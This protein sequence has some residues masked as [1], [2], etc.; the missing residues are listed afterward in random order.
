VVEK[1]SGKWPQAV[2]IGYGLVIL[3]LIKDWIV[4]LRPLPCAPETKILNDILND[5]VGDELH[6]SP[7]CFALSL[8]KSCFVYKLIDGKM[9]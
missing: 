1:V 4:V 7:K 5:N 8:S 9:G 6:P 3:C 2:L